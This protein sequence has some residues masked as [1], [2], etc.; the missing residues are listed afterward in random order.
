MEGRRITLIPMDN[1]AYSGSV[2]FRSEGD[3]S[4]PAVWPPPGYND[5]PPGVSI[6][7]TQT[8]V[9]DGGS[10][11]TSG[12]VNDWPDAPT[13]PGNWFPW[14]PV[15]D[16]PDE[17]VYPGVLERQ[18]GFITFD[19]SEVDV[20]TMPEAELVLHLEFSG[21]ESGNPAWMWAF[22]IAGSSLDPSEPDP[23]YVG[24]S[25]DNYS[26]NTAVQVDWIG[27][28]FD[29][30]DNFADLVAAKA[31]EWPFEEAVASL[32]IADYMEW[33]ETILPPPFT[34]SSWSFEGPTIARLELRIANWRSMLRDSDWV[35]FF[36]TGADEPKHF[37]MWQDRNGGYILPDESEIHPYVARNYIPFSPQ[38]QFHNGHP[39]FD[40]SL[41][42]I[43]LAAEILLA[44]EVTLNPLTVSGRLQVD[45]DRPPLIHTARQRRGW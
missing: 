28:S 17:L 22:G 30:L 32:D 36:F 41:R 44:G 11:G 3:T 16:A 42:V 43:P 34:G 18:V 33:K 6:G 35:T 27:G 4:S 31:S 12:D 10:F 13:T 40:V 29:D 19:V 1:A 23:D 20:N 45:R 39:L 24:S 9:A 21:E 38:V 5:G 26:R 37:W 25:P 2:I 7:P 14:P 15:R 8:L